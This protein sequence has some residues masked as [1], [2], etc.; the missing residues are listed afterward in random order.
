[1]NTPLNA[2]IIGGNRFFGRHLAESLVQTGARVTLLNRGNRDDGLGETVSRLHCDRTNEIA[3]REAVQGQ[4]WDIIYDQICFTARDAR[5]ACRIFEGKTPRYIFTSTVSVYNLGAGLHED[6]FIPHD[7]F[8]DPSAETDADY[9]EAKR[10]AE[11]TFAHEAPFDVVMARFPIVC[12]EDDYTGRLQF[13]IDHVR[14]GTSMWIPNLQARMSYIDSAEAGACL[15]FLG[16]SE[17]EGPV[18]CSSPDA[19]SI[20]ELL[21]M[22][23]STVGR[24]AVLAQNPQSG[25]PSPYGM[26]SDYF[27]STERLERAGFRVRNLREWLP[28]LVSRLAQ[29]RG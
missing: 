29:P 23:E 27:P 13:H 7:Y 24:K 10:Q 5:A 20:G 11:A 15:K 16:E 2:L 28:Q 9:G 1:M 19:I 21:E 4:S 26:E 3:L 14:N 18:N 12:G 6:L 25:D 17:L 8:F 22:I